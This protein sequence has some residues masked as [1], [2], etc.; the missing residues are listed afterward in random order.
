M[1]RFCASRRKAYQA[2]LYLAKVYLAGSNACRRAGEALTEE[3]MDFFEKFQ[4]RK[5][6]LRTLHGYP[7]V[8]ALITT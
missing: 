4:E 2:S 7:I 6:P 1:Q 3:D 5:E 8:R